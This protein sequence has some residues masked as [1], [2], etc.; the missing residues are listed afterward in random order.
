MTLLELLYDVPPYYGAVVFLLTCVF[1]A[2]VRSRAALLDHVPGPWLSRYTDALR[3][4]LTM[5]YS[6]QDVNLYMKL[7]SQDGDVV[8]VGP[9]SVSVLDP[10]AILTI[11]GLN[12]RLNKVCLLPL[13]FQP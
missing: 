12:A 2:V 4:Y 3:A 13:T 11:Y 8:R 1:I 7:H 10:Q 5:K 6:G 9:R